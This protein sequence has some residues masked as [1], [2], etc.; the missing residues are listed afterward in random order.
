[1]N[2]LNNIAVKMLNSAL[3][4]KVKKALLHLSYHLAQPISDDLLTPIVSAQ[5]WLSV[6][7]PWPRVASILEQLSML[8][9]TKEGGAKWLTGFGRIATPL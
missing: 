2:A 3:P 6:L 1:M 5:A 8:A 7:S 4:H 9:L